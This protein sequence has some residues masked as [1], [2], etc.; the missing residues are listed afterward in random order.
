MNSAMTSLCRSYPV[1]GLPNNI[2]Y[3]EN[4]LCETI[5]KYCSDKSFFQHKEKVNNA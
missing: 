2:E 4:I 3:G 1:L 5:A